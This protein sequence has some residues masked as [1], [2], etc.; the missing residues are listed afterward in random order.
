MV[1]FRDMTI[2][3]YI[4][5]SLGYNYNSSYIINH[6]NYIIIHNNYFTNYDNYLHNNKYLNDYNN[7]YI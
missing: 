4:F 1:Y 3:L 2:A 6:N 5:V 7:N